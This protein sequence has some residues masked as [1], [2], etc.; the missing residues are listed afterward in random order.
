[1]VQDMAVPMEVTQRLAMAEQV[2]G[3]VR[4]VRRRVE[5]RHME[6]RRMDRAG[7]RTSLKET[8][9]CKTLHGLAFKRWRHRNGAL[10]DKA[11]HTEQ[12]EYLKAIS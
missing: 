12:F 6:L 9:A 2:P 5:R 11:A 4:E 3:V 7:E 1:M 10:P 8:M